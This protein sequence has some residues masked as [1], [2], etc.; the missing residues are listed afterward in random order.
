MDQNG[1][2]F[3]RAEFIEAVNDGDAERVKAV[4]ADS[5]QLSEYIDEPWFAFDAPAIVFAASMVNRP[6]VEVLLDAGASIDIKSSWWAG[7]TSALQHA[8][9]SMLGYNRELAEYL[10]ERGATVD[11]H[12][13][14][15]LDM[16]ETLEALIR[17][18]SDVVNAPGCDGM[19]PLH[20]AATPRI[21]ELL[22]AQG[23]NINLRDRDHNGTP[24]QW[25]MRRRPEVCR[26]LLEQGAEADVVLYCVMGDV[27]HAKTEFQKNPELLNLRINVKS[28]N[29]YVI[30][31]LKSADL[32]N[33]QTNE[34]RGGHVYAYQVG[35]TM[36][37]LEIALQSQQPAIVDLLIDS[38]YEINLRDWYVLVGQGPRRFD[39]LVKGFLAKGL[40]INGLQKHRRGMWA[41][42][43][44]LAQRGLTN[45]IA[46]L[47]A[48]G[49]DPNVTDDKGQTP[50][51]FIAQKGIGKNQAEML[52]EHGADLNARDDLGQTPLDYAKRA[53]RKTV[54]DFLTELKMKDS[55]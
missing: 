27:E 36:P 37:L 17:E 23:A 1:R 8:A 34:V 50:L 29:G 15:G 35:P 40:D 39:T 55:K 45:G 38:G 9:G 51:H 25:T 48:N 19:S 3:P 20:F 13:A 41:P 7:G 47:L 30:P 10:I 44:W 22:L 4:L 33:Q 11:A 12:A 46:G 5:T 31:T 52:V 16:V 28:P 43:H 6:L 49:A 21:A 53:K 26:Y 14:A 54:A 42:L 24:A 18:N 32:E 2:H